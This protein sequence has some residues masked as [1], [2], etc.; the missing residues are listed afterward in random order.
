MT[1]NERSTKRDLNCMHFLLPVNGGKNSYVDSIF[2]FFCL[3]SWHASFEPRFA[4]T[5]WFIKKCLYTVLL[6]KKTLELLH[7]PTL[8]YINAIGAEFHADY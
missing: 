5:S 4:Y 3:F 8:F 1:M 6:S 7:F 2:T